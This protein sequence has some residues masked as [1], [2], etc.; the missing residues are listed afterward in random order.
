MR[1]AHILAD[2]QLRLI[3]ECHA[4]CLTDHE[5]CMQNGISP[6]NF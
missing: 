6:E 5:W 4:S 2:E 1:A 3:T